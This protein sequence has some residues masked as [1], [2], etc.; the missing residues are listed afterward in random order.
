MK[1]SFSSLIALT[2]ILG[3]SILTG[4]TAEDKSYTYQYS[5]NGC[6]TGSHNFDSKAD[7]CAA[8]KNES[9]NN[10]CASDLRESAHQ[11]DCSS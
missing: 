5:E 1:M 10:G 8:L 7:Y 9:L 3:I 2:G 4:C 11:Q 6:D